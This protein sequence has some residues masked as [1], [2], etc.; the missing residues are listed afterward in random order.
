MTEYVLITSFVFCSVSLF[1]S[2]VVWYIIEKLSSSLSVF[3][4]LINDLLFFPTVKLFLLIRSALWIFLWNIKYLKVDLSPHKHFD[5]CKQCVFV[6]L[7]SFSISQRS[8]P[9]RCTLESGFL[10][11]LQSFCL[12]ASS[13]ALPSVFPLETPSSL[14]SH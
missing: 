2:H 6:Y 1:F 9:Y 13:V 7:A 10:C 11:L 3:V 8:G 14:P 5:T 12:H 4:K